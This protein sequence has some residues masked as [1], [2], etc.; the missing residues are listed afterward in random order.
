[1]YANNKKKGAAS[2][3]DKEKP[4]IKLHRVNAQLS[5]NNLVI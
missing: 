4:N 1:M 5:L 3:K 2:L